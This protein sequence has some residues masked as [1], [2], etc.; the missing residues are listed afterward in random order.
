M[1]LMAISNVVAGC[2]AKPP[3]DMDRR[4]RPVAWPAQRSHRTGA[5]PSSFTARTV[6]HLRQ[7]GINNRITR[8]SKLHWLP[9][10]LAYFDE[11][12][13]GA[14][15]VNWLTRLTS[16]AASLVLPSKVSISA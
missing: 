16:A 3:I 10:V 9:L 15:F 12:A 13:G 1:M 14:S 11:L 5:T 2:A 6:P 7:L 8:M 4:A